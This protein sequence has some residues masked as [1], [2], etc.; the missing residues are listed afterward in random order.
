MGRSVT[1]YAEKQICKNDEFFKHVINGSADA[2]T[3]KFQWKVV[4]FFYRFS[5]SSNEM[6]RGR[7]SRTCSLAASSSESESFLGW[8]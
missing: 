3:V 6:E 7:I 5:I 8:V 2:E 4:S 1:K